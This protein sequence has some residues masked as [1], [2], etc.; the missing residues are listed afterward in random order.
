MIEKART[1]VDMRIKLQIVQ[2]CCQKVSKYI[3]SWYRGWKSVE[4][5]C[6]AGSLISGLRRSGELISS[7]QGP[8]SLGNIF[9]STDFRVQSCPESLSRTRVINGALEPGH[10]PGLDRQEGGRN[11]LALR[12]YGIFMAWKQFCPA[13]PAN[14]VTDICELDTSLPLSAV[15]Y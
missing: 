7:W 14:T 2:M 13:C 10:W 15:T 3:Y 5:L 11:P 8:R 12:G 9:G 1:R 4:I 6:G